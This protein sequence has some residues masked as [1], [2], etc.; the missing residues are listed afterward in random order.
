MDG[1][2]FREQGIELS[3]EVKDTAQERSPL[4]NL[5]QLAGPITI[6]TSSYTRPH[7]TIRPLS[8]IPTPYH[9][10]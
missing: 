6:R 8:S 9:R 7:R 4:N 10:P 5:I 3:K 2:K 1:I